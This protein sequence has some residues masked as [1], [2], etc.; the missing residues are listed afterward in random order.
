M[1]FNPNK[2]QV[3]HI[4]RPKQ[5]L[6]TYDS[7]NGQVLEATDTAKY[8]GVNTSK[9]NSWND[10]ISLII[11]KAIRMLGFVKPNVRTN[12]EKVKELAYKTS[13]R[14]Q[15]E[16]TYLAWSPHTKQNINKC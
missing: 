2:C 11:V 10:H 9:G 13:V 12:D 3:L 16:Y 7:L 4:T 14:T 5:P 15:V 8:I 6:N 1:E